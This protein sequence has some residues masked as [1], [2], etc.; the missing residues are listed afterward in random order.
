M[1]YEGKSYTEERRIERRLV[2]FYECQL[3]G[4]MEHTAVE[5][6]GQFKRA[7]FLMK[8]AKDDARPTQCSGRVWEEDAGM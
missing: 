4:G 1:E 6:G 5:G 8:R 2:A 7:Y 3:V